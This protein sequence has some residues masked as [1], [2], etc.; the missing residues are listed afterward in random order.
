MSAVLAATAAAQTRPGFDAV[1]IKVSQ[2]PL[3]VVY[4]H[5][6]PKHLDYR[7]VT[8]SEC[9]G[10]AYGLD[11]RLIVGPEWLTADRYTIVARIEKE[12]PAD[13]MMSMLRS[14]L[15][16]RFHLVSHFEKRNQAVYALVTGEHGIKLKML[17]AKVIPSFDRRPIRGLAFHFSVRSMPDFVKFPSARLIYIWIEWR[18]MRPE[19]KGVL[20]S[21]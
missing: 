19:W 8:L 20:I 6:E 15:E 17:P 13:D 5:N 12:V 7:N 9:I 4:F 16:D 14:T 10:R 3:D 1:S 2:P 21:L 11:V 18:W